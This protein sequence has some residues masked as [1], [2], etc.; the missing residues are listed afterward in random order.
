MRNKIFDDIYNQKVDLSF[1]DLS[2]DTSLKSKDFKKILT[3]DYAPESIEN[4]LEAARNNPYRK[5]SEEEANIIN[6]ELQKNIKE[7][8]ELIS[9]IKKRKEDIYDEVS[10]S[11]N[12]FT[13]KIENNASLLEAANNV[14]GGNKNSI[15]YEDYVTLLEMKKQIQFNETRDLMNEVFDDF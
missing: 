14:F 4:I 8:K 6:K 13:L 5:F 7:A 15:T 1:K 10:N 9:E 11:E 12:K 2:R 3:E